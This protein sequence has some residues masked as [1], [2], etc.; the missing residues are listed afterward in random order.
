MK[1]FG[2]PIV[3]TK[4]GNRPST[5]IS[6]CGRSQCYQ[7]GENCSPCVSNVYVYQEQETVKWVTT[8]LEP[9]VSDDIHPRIADIA[10]SQTS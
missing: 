9:K 8:E 5:D 10:A 6:R 4:V 1:Y 7:A 2:Y 3:A